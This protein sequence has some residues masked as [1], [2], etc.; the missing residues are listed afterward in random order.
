[1]ALR[2]RIAPRRRAVAE[3]ETATNGR[4]GRAAADERPAR[5]RRG[6]GRRAGVGASRGLNLLA[7]LVDLIVSVIAI[8]IVAGILFVVLDA[9]K[10]NSIVSHVHDWAKWLVGPFD[11]LFTP[12]NHKVEIA[13]NWG[14]ALVVYLFVG[15]L[16]ARLLRRAGPAA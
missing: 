6:F 5:R 14:I 15:R 8:I 1:M 10:D 3:E 13:V 7:S 9:N 11:G 4:N 2:D 16:I 12:K